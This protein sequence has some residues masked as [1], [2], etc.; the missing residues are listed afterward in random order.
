[1]TRPG[2]GSFGVQGKKKTYMAKGEIHYPVLQPPKAC[3]IQ[4]PFW[5]P[6]SPP[7]DPL[8]LTAASADPY[9]LKLAGILEKY[10]CLH[11]KVTLQSALM[12]AIIPMG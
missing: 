5:R 4:E 1:M 2:G 8:E 11:N 3:D 10:P 7:S 9:I 12:S 6:C